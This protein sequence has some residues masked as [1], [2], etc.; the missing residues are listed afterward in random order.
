MAITGTRAVGDEVSFKDM[1]VEIDQTPAS[2]SFVAVETWASNVTVSGGDANV[3]ELLTYGGD[4]II[5][6]GEQN[7][8]TVEIE[9]VYTEVDTAPFKEIYDDFSADPGLRQDARWSPKGGS[10][11]DYQFTTSGGRLI[12]CTLP[13]RPAADGQPAVFTITIRCSSIALADVPV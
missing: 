9:M 8:Y 12:N 3:G 11:G 13:Q 4:P 2:S 10:T 6:T 1:K 7:P 5:L